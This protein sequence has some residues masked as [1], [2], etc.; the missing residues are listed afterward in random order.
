MYKGVLDCIY[1]TEIA[2]LILHRLDNRDIVIVYAQIPIE[3]KI[4]SSI[5]IGEIDYS[6]WYF[7]DMSPI[8][9]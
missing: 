6:G 2:S 1:L 5:S 7:I 9:L 3:N 4:E 8:I